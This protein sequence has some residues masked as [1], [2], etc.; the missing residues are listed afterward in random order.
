MKNTR[1][2]L[3]WK[4]FFTYLISTLIFIC[5][6]V[7]MFSE[8]SRLW[9]KSYTDQIESSLNHNAK[10]LSGDLANLY[11]LPRIMNI[12]EDFNT[13]TREKTVYSSKHS[14]FI[15]Y[16][17]NNLSDQI[18][19]FEPISD[20]IIHLR[21]SG[22]CITPDSFYPSIQKLTDTFQYRETDL[23][24]EIEKK[25][26]QSTSLQMLPCDSVTIK[27]AGIED[28]VTCVMKESADNC[29]YIFLIEK[30]KLY[31]YFQLDSLPKSVHFV[32]SD[33][34]G[35]VL[36]D[37]DPS[38]AAVKQ[39]TEAFVTFT[40]E[41]PAVKASAS[42]SI[43]RSFFKSVTREAQQTVYLIISLSLF[44]GLILSFAF[45][46]INSQPIRELISAQQIPA[47]KQSKNELVTIYN[48]LSESKEQQHSMQEKLLSGLLMRVFSG[49]TVSDED[50]NGI[51]ENSVLRAVSA[52]IAVVRF[53]NTHENQEFQSLM[54]YQLKEYM[55]P[56]F[57]IEPMNRQELGL[58]LP[59]ADEAVFKL[60]AYLNEVN[61]DLTDSARI[62]CGVSAPF[63]GSEGISI[64]VRQARFTLPNGNECFSIFSGSGELSQQKSQL[65]DYKE[66]QVALFNWN[67]KKVDEL[68]QEFADAVMKQS[69]TAAQ[70]VFYTLLT[71][72]KDAAAAVD[73]PSAIFKE[74]TYARDI[75]ADANIRRLNELTNYL[76]E[77]KVTCQSD[78]KKLRN[79]EIVSYLRS[80][81]DD[82]LLSAVSVAEV[83]G[84]S[85]RTI[86]NI[87]SEET[88]M[89]F[90]SYLSDVRMQKAGE[91]LRDTTLDASM[92]AEKVGLTTSTFYRN[93]KNYYHL[94][95]AGYKSQFSGEDTD[96]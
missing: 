35:T 1:L 25:P 71:F 79:R 17:M 18:S 63:S 59:A 10:A 86:K 26:A 46:R 48:Y 85:E 13:L 38:A 36:L 9:E 19:F 74:Y 66:F 42:I 21:K 80:H 87:L 30:A 62:I 16:S 3:F 20:V 22:I 73:V 67:I 94:P 81:Y 77:K 82:P 69:S 54:L 68:I 11:F 49:L 41:I 34:N 65:R 70:E 72:I 58:V 50:F 12:S 90:A 33:Q 83:Y 8:T 47:E 14:R 24:N 89:S 64:A 60:K 31:D 45:S 39:Q 4:C 28:Y 88:G 56:E 27:N 96:Q 43:P 55:P 78:E 23:I 53:K 57:I 37:N 92:I 32:L 40:T 15:S 7:Y 84:C 6:Q 5:V 51:A 91:L 61:S 76:F 95:P 52:R 93:F 44:L 75:S 2:S 29:T